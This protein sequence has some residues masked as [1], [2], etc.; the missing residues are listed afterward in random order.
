MD[1]GDEVNSELNFDP[2][3]DELY[4]AFDDLMLEYKKLKRKSKYIN[5]LNQD[6]SRQ[7]EIVTKEKDDLSKE[8]QKL[9]Q[10]IEELEN[11]NI[12]LTNELNT[13]K[14]ELDKT[15]PLFDKFTLSS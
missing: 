12:N 13:T 14:K 9:N 2:S 8:N 10:K 4:E 6:L 5:V 1:H 15:K 11:L 3:L 7:I